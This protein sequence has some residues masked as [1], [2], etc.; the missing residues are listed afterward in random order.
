MELTQTKNKI[1]FRLLAVGVA[2][3]L[4]LALVMTFWPA[5]QIF[6]YV[7]ALVMALVIWLQPLWGLYVLLAGVPFLPTTQLGYLLILTIG[8]AAGN[9]LV[10]KQKVFLTT[11]VDAPVLA[12][13][14]TVVL[15]A[16]FSITRS[17]SLNVLSLYGLY[18]GAFYLAATLPRSKDVSW[19][20]GGLLLAG[21]LAALLGLWQYKS[22]VQ[23]SLS[24][25]D[26]KQAESIR[27]R[28]FGPFDN[29]NIFAEYMTFV[30]PVALVLVVT[31]SRWTRRLGWAAVLSL[32]SVALIL[33]FSRGGWLAT[34]AA[35]IMLGLFWEPKIFIAGTILA[36]LLPMVASQQIIQRTSSIGSLE[37]S[38]NTFRLAIWAAVISMIKAYW[39]SGI[40]L[41]TAAFNQ[42][43][44]QFMIAGTPAIHTHNLYLQLALELGVFG[45]LAFLWL[46]MAVFA[47]CL[48]ALSQISYRRRGVLAALIAG[49]TGFL[50][51]GAVDNVWYSP[52]L[53][54]LFWLMF[55]LTVPLTREVCDPASAACD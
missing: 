18:F 30:L 4:I 38:S 5:K 49:L 48:R 17:N 20:L 14:A 9:K 21:A 19:L 33:T 40:G 31:E 16:L 47:N 50:L 41:G 45:L 39:F 36:F 43:Y 25:I 29:P 10:A 12:F 52:K 53:T 11:K 46:L 1:D 32:S 42:V 37:D 24:W 6:K 13:F 26:I 27:T 3:G 8:A 7:V 35:A 2:S 15:A 54:L 51:H 23:T 44:P 34:L 55:G 22:G 28:V